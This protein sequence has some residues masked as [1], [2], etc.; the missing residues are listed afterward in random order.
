MTQAVTCSLA[1]QCKMADIFISFMNFYIVSGISNLQT[2]Q[3]K[4]AWEREKEKR[5]HGEE[6][7]EEFDQ[8]YFLNK[9]FGTLVW[10]KL[11]KNITSSLTSSS[12]P[13][14]PR[15]ASRA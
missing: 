4:C 12:F 9:C 6:W 8:Q 7:W 10:K 3:Q 5:V 14:F 13:I 1:K 15:L 2:S 11:Q